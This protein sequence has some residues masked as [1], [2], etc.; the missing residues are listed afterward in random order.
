MPS[1]CDSS[2]FGTQRNFNFTLDAI[3]LIKGS[4]KAIAKEINAMLRF[5]KKKRISTHFVPPISDILS[6]TPSLFKINLLKFKG[7][8]FYV[9]E[10]AGIEPASKKPTS[11][12]LHA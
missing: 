1:N 12:V 9:V 7:L 11:S 6:S 4:W 3:A 5:E 8:S 10:L 2:I